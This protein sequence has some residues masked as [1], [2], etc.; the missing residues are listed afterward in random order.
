VEGYLCVWH[1]LPHEFKWFL[2]RNGHVVYAINNDGTP[3]TLKEYGRDPL[4]HEN[5]LDAYRPPDAMG[6]NPHELTCSDAYVGK[7]SAAAGTI[8]LYTPYLSHEEHLYSNPD[9]KLK[10]RETDETLLLTLK[11]FSNARLSFEGSKKL[12][13]HVLSK[14]LTVSRPMIDELT[15]NVSYKYM[16]FYL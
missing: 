5:P 16:H 11:L 7:G 6:F 9:P 14:E 1:F 8:H 4:Y 2:H 10:R 12:D 15:M 13:I 3:R